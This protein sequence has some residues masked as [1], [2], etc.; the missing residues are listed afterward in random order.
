MGAAHLTDGAT[1][2]QLFDREL[3]PAL[4]GL[5]S[6]G[7]AA[8]IR[9]AGPLREAMIFD[10]LVRLPNDLLARTDRA[11]M[12]VSLETRV[13]FMD[14]HLVEL[15]NTLPDAWCVHLR[16]FEG[17]WL[18]KRILA[19][20]VPRSVVYRP[21]RGFDLPIEAWLR[22]EFSD[23]ARAYLGERAVPGLGYGFLSSAYEDLAN[24]SKAGKASKG[25]K[26]EAVLW[27]WLVLEKWFRMWIGREASPPPPVIL[28]SRQAYA[29]LRAAAD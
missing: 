21:K 8:E 4:D 15:A 7:F 18:L 23:L 10:Q 27:A 20:L 1:R 19:R 6:G 24:G 16:R 28:G 14:H 17:K 26:H 29:T 13:P 11:T 2:Q 5:D 9:G 12:A 22:Q 3:R 25:R